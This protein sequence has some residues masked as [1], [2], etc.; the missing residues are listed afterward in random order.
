MGD[1][2]ERRVVSCTSYSSSQLPGW[3][4]GYRRLVMPFYDNLS[5]LLFALTAME[6]AGHGLKPLKSGAK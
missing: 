6:P 2:F 4:E 1:V 3:H 5:A